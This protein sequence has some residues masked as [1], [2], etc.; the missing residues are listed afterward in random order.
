MS[1]SK[2][3]LY[4]AML[5]LGGNRDGRYITGLP[6]VNELLKTLKLCF[7]KEAMPIR[8]NYLT[9]VGNILCRI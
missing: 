6:H 8:Y 7:F 3:E 9:I 1:H 5:Q 2:E 4:L